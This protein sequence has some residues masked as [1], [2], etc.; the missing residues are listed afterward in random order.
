MVAYSQELV[1]VTGGAGLIGS[2]LI[3]ELLAQNAEVRTVLHGHPLEENANRVDCMK[4]DLTK[5]DDCLAAVENVEC[6]FQAAA[7]VGGVGR[8]KSH[9]AQMY[10]TNMLIQTN[11]LEAAR[12]RD[13]DRYLYTSSC[14]LYPRDVTLMSEDKAWDG[15]P[16]PTN[17]SYGWVKRMGELQCLAYAE[18]YGMKIA[19]VRP[20]N[21]YGPGDNFDLETSHAIPALIRKAVEK[22]DPYVVWGRGEV[23]R[24]FIH[25]KDVAGGMMLALQKHCVADP[26]NLGTGREI[27]IRDL[28]SLILKLSGHDP[29]KL[30]FDEARP[31]GQLGRRTDTNKAREKIGFV[32]R[33]TLEEGLKDTIDWYCKH[34]QGT[35]A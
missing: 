27:K 19:I 28:A 1:L 6:V 25:A 34:C 31:V 18:E 7:L 9:P 35:P 30:V 20:T 15:P 32:A 4:G 29:A 26:I 23:S 3:K 8:N 13:I 21:T 33:I 14:C 22:Q 24:D 12:L 11:M 2:H 10:T 16:E 5:L 17:T